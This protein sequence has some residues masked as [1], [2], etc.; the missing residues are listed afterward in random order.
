MAWLP[1]PRHLVHRGLWIPG[2]RAGVDSPLR[3]AC[4]P[5]RQETCPSRGLST[6]RRPRSDRNVTFPI[7]S[8]PCTADYSSRSRELYPAV[9]PA[10]APS[11]AGHQMVSD[12]VV[13]S[14]R[15]ERA[16]AFLIVYWWFRVG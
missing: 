4:L 8:R 5:E 7:Q 11:L 6:P 12:A 13:L 10:H 15:S 14:E 2:R 1:P 3:T 9:Q 16:H